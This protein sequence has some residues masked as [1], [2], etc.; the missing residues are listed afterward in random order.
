MKT[1]TSIVAVLAVLSVAPR[2]AAQP[3]PELPA[4]EATNIAHDEFER[5]LRF[6]RGPFEVICNFSGDWRRLPC[7]GRAIE[8]ATNG[9]A[10]LSEGSLK[11]P[12][13]SGAL[14]R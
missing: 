5:W 2:V 9:W 4:G 3:A 8:L 14:I 6:R 12:P 11:L 1:L 13:M 10:L 7:T